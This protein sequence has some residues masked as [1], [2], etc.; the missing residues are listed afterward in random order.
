MSIFSEYILSI[1]RKVE[2]TEEILPIS[3]EAIEDCISVLK[4]FRIQRKRDVFLFLSAV[5]LLNAAIKR[6]E[7]KNGPGY[8]FI[9]GKALLAARIIVTRYRSRS[10]SAFKPLSPAFLKK[11]G[12]GSSPTL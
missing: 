5:N 2:E 3:Q 4:T 1:Y 8:G 7:Y 6:P 10:R 11:S 9:K 12:F